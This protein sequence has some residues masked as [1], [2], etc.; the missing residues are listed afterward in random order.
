MKKN[1]LLI[2][3]I[4]VIIILVVFLGIYFIKFHSKLSLNK[5]DWG[6][7]GSYFAG[8]IGICFSLLSI[9]LIYC[10][11]FQQ[12]KQQFETTFQ[13]Y[14]SNYYSL[15]NL[16]K[17]RWLH[18]TSDD[19]RNPIY[20]TGREI[21]GNAVEYIDTLDT[22]NKFI[23]IYCLHNNVFRHYFNHIV[24]LFNIIDNNIELTNNSK[25]L[26]IDRFLLMLSTYEIVFFGYYIEYIYK[27][28]HLE[29]IKTRLKTRFKDMEFY[30][31]FPHSKQIE[32][33]INRFK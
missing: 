18:N 14:I 13:Q 17:E 2:L 27:G 22:E 24:E 19:E 26:Y 4:S 6:Y 31:K 11:F 3:T 15:L 16:I 21:F 33:I 5:S 8:T 30:E 28:E 9:F 32:Y 12:R 10:T 20:Q 7:F 29:T 25:I 1:L 23:E